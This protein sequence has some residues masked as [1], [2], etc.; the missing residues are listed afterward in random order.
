MALFGA[1]EGIGLETWASNTPAVSTYIGKGVGALLTAVR[2]DERPT[3]DESFPV[4]TEGE[5]AGKRMRPDTRL[6]MRFPQSVR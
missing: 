2:N 5:H 6:Y 1:K 3:R 4:R